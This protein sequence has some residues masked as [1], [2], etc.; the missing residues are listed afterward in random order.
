M[1]SKLFKVKLLSNAEMERKRLATKFLYK[2]C[3]HPMYVGILI[4]YITH[5]NL[6]TDFYIV[7]LICL[8]I[9]TLIGIHFEEKQ[10][11]KKY[12]ASYLKFQKEV[13]KLNFIYGIYLLLRKN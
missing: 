5:S 10:L 8:L 9:Y 13:P 1:K 4:V 11:A 3:R 6:I 12:G 2:F 7:N